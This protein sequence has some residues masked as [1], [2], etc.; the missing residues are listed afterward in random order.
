MILLS[1]FFLYIKWDNFEMIFVSRCRF[2]RQVILFVNSSRQP[3]TTSNPFPL[4]SLIT[5]NN[6]NN[7][8]N[9]H[10]IRRLHH[11]T[12]CSKCPWGQASLCPFSDNNPQWRQ[13]AQRLWRPRPAT[14][15]TTATTIMSIVVAALETCST[16]SRLTW[17]TRLSSTMKKLMRY[18]LHRKDQS[19]DHASIN[20]T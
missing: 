2:I 19:N 1:F 9:I 11:T 20:V 18:P 6:S 4:S 16:R 12:R 13:L 14:S 15:F 7:N 3:I 5:W 17:I 10:T 8:N